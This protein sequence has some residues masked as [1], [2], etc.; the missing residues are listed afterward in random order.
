MFPTHLS[1]PFDIKMDRQ[2][3]RSDEK[4]QELRRKGM[5][6]SGKVLWGR[7]A[8]EAEDRGLDEGLH[9]VFPL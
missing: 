6:G 1:S 5:L 7:R 9:L 3:E 8:G 4:W 2:R